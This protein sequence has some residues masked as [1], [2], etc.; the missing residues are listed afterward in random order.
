MGRDIMIIDFAPSCALIVPMTRTLTTAETNDSDCRADATNKQVFKVSHILLD[1]SLRKVPEVIKFSMGCFPAGE[2]GGFPGI[3]TA[4]GANNRR[5][6]K[7]K[8][9]SAA[10]LRDSDEKLLQKRCSASQ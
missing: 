7:D 2:R 5:W 9:I 10:L 3:L 1:L 8:S 4:D 6:E